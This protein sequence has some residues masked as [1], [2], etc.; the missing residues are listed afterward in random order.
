MEI[1]TEL[2]SDILE[3]KL[4]R[5]SLVEELGRGSFGV[6]YR[7]TDG[8][9][10]AALKAFIL[11]ARRGVEGSSVT[12]A[13]E[14]VDRDWKRFAQDYKRLRSGAL[15]G[16]QDFFRHDIEMGEKSARAVG[17]VLMDHYPTNLHD[18][19]M[20]RYPL[21]ADEVQRLFEFVT[22]RLGRLH[23]E[24]DFL[25]EDLKPENVLLEEDGTGLVLGDFGGLRS[26]SS[27]STQGQFTMDFAAPERLRGEKGRGVPSVVYALGLL[28]YWLAAGQVPYEEDGPLERVNRLHQE[29][30]PATGDVNQRLAGIRPALARCLRQDPDARPATFEAVLAPA[31]S[32]AVG[33]G[34]GNA[35]ADEQAYPGPTRKDGRDTVGPGRPE[36]AAPAPAGGDHG[37]APTG[38]RAFEILQDAPFAPEMVVIPPG[39][40]WMGSPDDDPEALDAEKPRHRV[41]IGYWL[42]VGKY[43]VTFDEFD[44]FVQDA[45]YEHK[46]KDQGCR[47]DRPVIR[48]S[49][50]DAETYLEW[51]NDKTAG[52]RGGPRYRLLTEAEWEYVAR[53]GT[54]TRYWWGN[55]ITSDHANY[56]LNNWRTVPVG[57]YRPN[58]FGLYQVHGNV[59]EWVADCWHDDYEGAPTD[60]SAWL[61]GD[62]GNC[63]RR[64]LRGGS[65]N[66]VPRYLRSANRLGITTVNRSDSLGFRVAR[67]L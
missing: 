57:E 12:G 36:P 52:V 56:D 42:A 64:V 37:V 3:E 4:P 7:V 58:P 13:A 43:A 62:G 2:V 26:T 11:A 30:L 44:R 59:Y 17:V 24:T 48:V 21:P 14:R 5:W 63:S 29:G 53:A 6:V 49:W 60:G 9:R 50:E 39:D 27:G 25:Y 55:E 19:V 20:D 15:V 18:W 32:E 34:P 46:P 22:E 1:T 28:G 33:S 65:W 54:E 35:R 16:F 66:Y 40:F 45:G 61:E 51:L 23:R 67:T 10:D 8:S 41:S 38:H 31:E 47:G